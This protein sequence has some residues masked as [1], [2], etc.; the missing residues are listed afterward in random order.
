MT[1]ES[2]YRFEKENSRTVLE[3]V[4]RLHNELEEGYHFISDAP[5]EDPYQYVYAVKRLP[6][7]GY[8]CL[9]VDIICTRKDGAVTTY[10]KRTDDELYAIEFYTRMS[11][12]DFTA[13]I[14]QVLILTICAVLLPCFFGV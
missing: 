13:E 6:D 11:W 7:G 2:T 9:E 3:L 4:S 5:G 10:I 14:L 1:H 8:E 12:P